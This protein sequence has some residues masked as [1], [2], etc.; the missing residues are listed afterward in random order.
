MIALAAL[1]A[2][3]VPQAAPAP[4]AAAGAAAD[5]GRVAVA[6][7]VAAKLMPAG[8]YRVMM[9]SVFDQITNGMMTQM[10]DLPMRDLVKMG[11][12]S[13]AEAAK[14]GPATSRQIMAIVDPAFDQRMQITMRVMMGEMTELLATLE[15]DYRAGLADGLA[16]G[17][18][19]AQLEELE[20][21]FAT[22]TGSAYAGQSMLLYANPAMMQRMQAMM[23]KIMEAMPRIISK[24][25]AATAGLPAPTKAADLTPEQRKKLAALL[26]GSDK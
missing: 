2:L 26:Q 22:P 14:I 5:P 7:R 23:P 19:A 12:I 25:A 11:G 10:L 3:G 9:K 1:L 24:T 6:Q 21:F 8:V 20:R 15:P 17:F 16:A 13:E 18:S 4:A